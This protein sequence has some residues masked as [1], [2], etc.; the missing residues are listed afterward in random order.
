MSDLGRIGANI[1][2]LR[3]AYGETQEGLGAVLNVEKKY[4]FI[5]REW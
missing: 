2:S 5:L 3:R 1:R 4:G